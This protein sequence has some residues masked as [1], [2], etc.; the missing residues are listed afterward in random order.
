MRVL[1]ISALF[2]PSAVGGAEMSAL[3][4]ALWLRDQGHEVGVL[5][6]A[7]C[8][9][10]AAADMVENGLRLW[11]V[12]LPRPYATID[13]FDQ[14]QIMKAVWHVQDHIDPRNRAALAPVLD[15]F[16]P[17]FINVHLLAGLGFNVLA[18]IGRRDIP[19]MFALHDPGLVCVRSSMFRH[20][21]ECRQQCASCGISGWWKAR[22]VARVRRIGFYSPSVANLAR[23]RRYFDFADRPTKVTLDANRYPEPTVPARASNAL[24]FLYVGRL[25]PTKGAAVLLAAADSLAER[26][27]FT[28]TIVGD[29]PDGR[30]LRALYG[31]RRWVRFTG[32]VDQQ[33]VSNEMAGGDVLCVPSLISE[34]SPGV[35]INGMGRGLAI[36]GSDQGGIPEL[37]QH[38]GNGLLVP[39]GNIAAWTAAMARLIA[40]RPLLDA[41]REDARTRANAFDP[42]AL[43]AGL[44]AFMEDIR[45]LRG[46]R[47]RR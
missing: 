32:M 24:R 6:A 13:Y 3:N 9:E 16:R 4:L 41:L 44:Y 7:T 8:P 29:G 10:E 31:N 36:I 42:E 15:A 37:V 39:P 21:R 46:W 19:V 35:I 33:T 5:T 11:R 25:H 47:G 17:D 45:A 14:P 1:V 28:V 40:D 23:I 30:R 2:P 20:G 38:E 22:M 12:W 27:R 18:E 43:G 26:E 34:N